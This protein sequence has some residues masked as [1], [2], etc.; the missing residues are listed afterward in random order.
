MDT[1]SPSISLKQFEYAWD[2]QVRLWKGI[3]GQ[4]YLR[5]ANIQF[6]EYN[7]EYPSVEITGERIASV[8]DP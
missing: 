5:F 3:Q 8:H 4:A 6:T 1:R 7:T 2:I